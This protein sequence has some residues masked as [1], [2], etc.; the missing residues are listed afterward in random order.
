CVAL[1]CMLQMN[2]RGVKLISR[3]SYENTAAVMGTPF[4]YP[5]S[6][7]IDE[8]DAIF[9]LDNVLIP[10]EDVFVY[11]DVDKANNFFP[12]TGFL[13]R[14]LMHGCT[15]LAVKLELLAGLMMKALEATAPQQLRAQP[16]HTCWCHTH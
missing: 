10:W 7:R 4:D 13:P 2:A 8:N 9:V 14:A 16:V 15:R 5:L 3:A 11:G 1:L 12:Q 6:S